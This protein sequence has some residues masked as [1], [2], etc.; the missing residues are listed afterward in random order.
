MSAIRDIEHLEDIQLMVDTFY[1]QIR[2]DDLIGPIFNEVIQDRW[3]EHLGK[4]YTFWQT[5][6]LD[7][8]TYFGRPFPP[9]SK[10]PVEKEHF[11]RW[12][13][14]FRGTIDRFF[15][16]E[17]AE[18]AKSQGE[19]MAEMFMYKIQ[20]FRENKGTPLL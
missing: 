2:E 15:K 12:I 19:K 6:L 16:G 11:E 7:E 14:L 13:S 20:F 3:P 5:V 17:K 4:M 8:H 1:G 9:H 10:L 18:K